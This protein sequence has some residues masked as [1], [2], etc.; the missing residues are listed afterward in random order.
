MCNYVL[1]IFKN[2]YKYTINNNKISMIL[3]R[4]RDQPYSINNA[5]SLYRRIF[6]LPIRNTSLL[7]RIPHA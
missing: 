3:G 5:D 2:I 6:P 7:Q 4:R 1:N